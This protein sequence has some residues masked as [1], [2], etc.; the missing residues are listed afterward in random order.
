M[1]G[2]ISRFGKNIWGQYKT[3]RSFYSYIVWIV[4]KIKKRFRV[5]FKCNACDSLMRVD[6]VIPTVSKDFIMLDHVIRSLK[7]IKHNVNKV[8]V[9][10]PRDVLVEKNSLY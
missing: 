5:G 1:R 7:H 2:L 10:A 3:R 4:L 9:V 6:V 8:Y